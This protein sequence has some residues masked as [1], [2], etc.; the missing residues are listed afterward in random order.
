[1]RFAIKKANSKAKDLDYFKNRAEIAEIL[2]SEQ[3][4][5]C[6][7]TEKYLGETDAG[8][9]EHF[10]DRLKNTLDDNYFNWYFVATWANRG[11]PKIINYQP[12]IQPEQAFDKNNGEI[13]RIFY[14]KNTNKYETVLKPDVAAQN[15]IDFID[16]N[17]QSLFF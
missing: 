1:M 4:N 2:K 3:Q 5:F 11:K 6:A 8:D 13:N 7:Y 17:H 12:I 14:D 10:N 9:I 16:L 15:L